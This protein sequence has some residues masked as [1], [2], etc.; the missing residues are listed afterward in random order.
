V[1]ALNAVVPQGTLAVAQ[2]VIDA[3]SISCMYIHMYICRSSFGLNT[4]IEQS[5]Y[6]N[7]EVAE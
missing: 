6:S 1:A 5:P 7:R 3:I 2:S 4:L